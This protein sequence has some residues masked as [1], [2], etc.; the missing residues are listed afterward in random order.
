MGIR[1]SFITSVSYPLKTAD[2]TICCVLSMSDD[3]TERFSFCNSQALDRAKSDPDKT[4][5]VGTKTSFKRL[6]SCTACLYNM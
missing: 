6:V 4:K 2:E 1:T 5:K 3:T